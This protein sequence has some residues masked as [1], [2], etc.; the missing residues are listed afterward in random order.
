MSALYDCWLRYDTNADS[1]NKKMLSTSFASI[2]VEN[3]DK[4]TDSAVEEVT[5]FCKALGLPAPKSVESGASL[6]LVSPVASIG[7]KDGYS[8]EKNDSGFTVSGESSTGL[9]YG[10]FSLLQGLAQGKSPEECCK[11]DYPRNEIRMM[12]QWDN[13]DGDIERGYAGRSIFFKDYKFMEDLSRIKD[14]ARLLASVGLNAISINNVNVHF[15]ETEFITPEYLPMVAKY[16]EVFNS[17]G[18]TMYMCINFAAPIQLGGIDV[19]DPLDERV[20]AWWKETAKTIYKAIPTFGGFLVKADSEGRPGPFTYGRNHADGSN[21]LAEAVKPYGGLVIWRCFVYNC[22]QDWRDRKTDRARA[23]YDHFMPLDGKFADNVILQ[24][25]NGPMDFQIREAVSPLLGAMP[26]TN[27]ILEFEVTQEYTGQ[28][29]HLCYLVPLWKEVLDFDTYAKGEGSYVKKMCDGSLYQPKHAGLAAVS[30]IGDDEC[31]TGSPLAQA[32]LYGYGRLCW[33]ADLTAEDIAKEWISL[34]LGTTKAI[35]DVMIP[36]LMT[37]RRTYENYTSPLGVGWMVTPHVHYGPSVDGYEY[38]RWGTYHFADWKGIG[39]DRTVATG[40][41]YTSQYFE[42]NAS[43]YENID[44]CPD[45]LLLFFHHV[46]YTHKLKSGKTLIQHIYDT[47]FDGVKTVEEYI[48]AWATLENMIQPDIFSLVK[49]R[50]NIQLEN[51]KEWRDIINTYF[52]RHTGTPDATGRR[53]YP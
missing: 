47:H 29:R 38:D 49:E 45:D 32:N 34:T 9:L 27:Q 19:S 6:R 46:D 44:T 41:G 3:G 15:H 48:R 12:N 53:I 8:I 20:R 51:S 16:N 4:I 25:K 37:S 17:Y 52:Y 24:I 14:Y 30:N 43:M 35:M 5:R 28:Q 31:W 22:N 18:I 33:N 11:S 13:G 39:V 42:P 40:T 23:A 2:S 1:L 36:M 7:H 21:M 26:N 50:L 10:V